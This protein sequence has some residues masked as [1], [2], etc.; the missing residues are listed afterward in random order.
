MRSTAFSGKVT[1]GTLVNLLGSLLLLAAPCC[2]RAQEHHF[3]NA[4]LQT[5]PLE[6]GLARTFKFLMDRVGGG[7]KVVEK[8]RF[9]IP[10][11]VTRSN[12]QKAGRIPCRL[13]GWSRGIDSRIRLGFD[14]SCDSWRPR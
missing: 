9:E 12:K 1:P 11:S 2:L 8:R 13:L 5:R 3:V 10:L 14:P 4:R 7:V 6:G